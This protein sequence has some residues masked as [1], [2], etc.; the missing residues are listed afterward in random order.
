[1]KTFIRMVLALCWIP[2]AQANI[3]YE[4][5]EYG[6][7]NPDPLADDLALNH[8]DGGFGWHDSLTD[9]ERQARAVP[10]QDMGYGAGL[11]YADLEVLGGAA[12]A[13]SPTPGAGG[14]GWNATANTWDAI[15]RTYWANPAIFQQ[16]DGF[17]LWVSAL[18]RIDSLAPTTNTNGTM[19]PSAQLSLTHSGMGATGVGFDGATSFLRLVSAAGNANSTVQVAN[20]ETY[21]LVLQLAYRETTVDRY[22]WVNP[23]Q[24]TLGGD[25]LASATASASV[26][27]GAKPTMHGKVYLDAFSLAVFDEIR[28]GTTY[29]SVTPVIPEP[30]SVLLLAGGL[31]AA[32]QLRRRG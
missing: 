14:W 21:L 27:G 19:N 11:S 26:L 17:S 29:A 28:V 4:G 24:S 16:Y 18:L 1:M 3:L 8:R 23:A 31:A 13:S 5:F 20:G 25:D 7:P 6:A 2:L 32:F 30:A 15:E 22:L 12:Y 9:W 10:Q